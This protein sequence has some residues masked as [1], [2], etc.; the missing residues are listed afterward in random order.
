MEKRDGHV[1]RRGHPQSTGA[2]ELAVRSPWA[3]SD[4]HFNKEV[5]SLVN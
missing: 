4:E 3:T 5:G 1:L 2:R